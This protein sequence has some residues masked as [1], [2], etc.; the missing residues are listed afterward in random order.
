MHAPRVKICGITRPRDAALAY[1][2]G[3]DYLGL[4][5]VAGPRRV[6][7]QA[8]LRIQAEVPPAA[9]DRPLA[10]VALCP[11]GQLDV[12]GPLVHTRQ[13]YAD[14]DYTPLNARPAAPPLRWWMVRHIDRREAIRDLAAELARLTHPPAA[15]VLDT[16]SKA[17]LGGTGQTFNWH[18]IADARAA[19]DLDRLPPIVL[20]GG[21]TPDNV[22]DAVCIARPFAVDVSSGVEV[23]G[24]TPGEKDAHKLRDF[25]QAVRS[26]V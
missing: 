17:A 5:F 15:V 11:I 4:N 13:I 20:A 10:Y 26:A 23:K 3:A 1:E 25:L 18:W 2:L 7:A 6:D 14:G 16:A 24:G 22:S 21:L 19:G 9:A 8:A 12:P